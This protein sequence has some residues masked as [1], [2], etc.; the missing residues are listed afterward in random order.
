MNDI[1][2]KKF[3]RY[4]VLEFSEKRGY[5]KIYLCR[6]DCGNIR[7]VVASHLI[8]NHS[9][10]C[11]CYAANKK[12]NSVVGKRFGRLIVLRFAFSRKTY[13]H[14]EC[15]CD[16]GEVKVVSY[17]SM[18]AGAIQSCGCL[19]RER[20]SA[21]NK[22]HGMSR[23]R[24][25]KVWHS[26]ISRC[27]NSKSKAFKWYGARNISVCKRWR[28]SFVNFLYDMGYPPTSKH[29]LDRE[30]NNGNYTPRNVIYR[31]QKEQMNNCRLNR[32]YTFNNKRHNVSQWSEL[33]GINKSTLQNR[34]KKMSIND[35]L[36]VPVNKKLRRNSSSL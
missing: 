20:T 32:W 31:T 22:T 17:H 15:R 34:L 26:M 24:I 29:S 2:G 8:N 12:I 4:T 33:T 36:T 35:A 10:S 11:G 7:K 25:Y 13:R 1:I 19:H 27:H 6:C 28:N 23:K 14:Y 18:N 16:C 3:N 21:K 9:K 30:N 5:S